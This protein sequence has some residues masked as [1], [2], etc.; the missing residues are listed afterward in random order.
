MKIVI[1]G[2]GYSGRAFAERMR[3]RAERIAGTTRSERNLDALRSSGI[4]PLLFDGVALPESTAAHLT[5]AT[6]LVVSV[7]PGET[8]DPALA[9]AGDVLRAMPHLAWIGY[10]STVGVYG[11]HDGAW[12]DEDADCRPTS[13]RSRARLEA[14]Q[15]WQ[16]FGD[17]KDVPV[18][19]LRLSGIYGPGRNAFVNLRDGKARRVIREGQVFNRIHVDDIAAAL[20]HLA[21]RNAGGIYN[22]S[23]SEPSPPQDVVSFA[24]ETMGVPPPPEVAFEDADFSPMARSFW[25]ENK[26][27]SNARLIGEGFV[28]GYPDYRTA[29][30]R[31]WRD[32]TWQGRAGDAVT[33]G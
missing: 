9:A 4:E 23:D 16:A 12:V 33:E 7:A 27:V 30:T 11:D 10:L 13:R 28:F 26:R 29:L 3:G 19:I 15:A 24:A 1:I 31:M 18:A 17:R 32:N 20:D 6:H 25:G 2:A 22:V 5:Q 14:E 21:S 8:G